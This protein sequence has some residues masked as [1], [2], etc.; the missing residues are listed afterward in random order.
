MN[1]QDDRRPL[2]APLRDEAGRLA[3]VISPSGGD[4]R[5]AMQLGGDVVTGWV[6]DLAQT[7]PGLPMNQVR[8]PQKALY[9][10][11]EP[12]A[13][14]AIAHM[15]MHGVK[16]LPAGL[17]TGMPDPKLI[18][19]RVHLRNKLR[20]M[21]AR[22]ARGMRFAS[23]LRGASGVFGHVQLSAVYE[24]VKAVINDAATTPD[25][26]ERYQHAFGTLLAH[27]EAQIQSSIDG[28]SEAQA[29]Q[30]LSAEEERRLADELIVADVAAAM[31]HGWPVDQ[32][33]LDQAADAYARIKAQAAAEAK[34]ETRKASR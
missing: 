31:N 29:A 20:H 32:S 10:R 34:P 28:R 6:V 17:V 33:T 22:T 21:R 15:V 24:H 8:P 23:N 12:A 19:S 4:L 26:R 3:L 18:E 5:A 25:I 2:A 27:R 1:K 13:S 11:R 30:T 7:T 9:R 14:D 16:S